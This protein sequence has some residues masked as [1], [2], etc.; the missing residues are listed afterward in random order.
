[1]KKKNK[2]LYIIRHSIAEKNSTKKDFERV[3]VS[4]GIDRCQK[5]AS[6]LEGKK[7][8]IFISSPAFRAKETAENIV[9]N[10]K[11]K[12]EII[13]EP[14]LYFC[15][16]ADFYEIIANASQQSVVIVSHNPTIHQFCLQLAE[17]KDSPAYEKLIK[18]FNQGSV[19]IFKDEEL[20][21]FLDGEEF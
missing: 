8:D 3:L 1:M 9:A 19:A 2:I 11:K 6:F 18:S 7:I 5:I 21:E 14:K 20:V 12:P 16:I 15:K 17:N 13:F 4:E 10:L